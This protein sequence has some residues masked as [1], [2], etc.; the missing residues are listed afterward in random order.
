VGNKVYLQCQRWPGVTAPLAWFGDNLVSAKLLSTGQAVRIEQRD[1]RVWLH[2]LPAY[3]PDG[4]MNV[5]ELTFDGEPKPS[6]PP[7]Q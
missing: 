5:I 1:D 3:P 4:H 2:D 6:S 7:Y